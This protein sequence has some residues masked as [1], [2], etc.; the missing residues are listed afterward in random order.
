[1]SRPDA[2]A[3]SVSEVNRRAR[4]TLERDFGELWV[5]G[6]LSGVSRP[7]EA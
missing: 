1:M 6:E 2:P 7:G 5:E 3:L 4:Q